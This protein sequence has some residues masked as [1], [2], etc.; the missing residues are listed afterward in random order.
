MIMKYKLYNIYSNVIYK[1]RIYDYIYIPIII[2]GIYIYLL[3]FKKI[4]L[5]N[6]Q[7]TN[8]IVSVCSV[9]AGFLFTA[10]TIIMGF[11]EEKPFIKLLKK[12][13]YYKK[14]FIEIILSEIFFILC[15]IFS[16]F[17]I[18]NNIASVLFVLGCC[19]TI[20]MLKLFATISFYVSQ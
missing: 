19:Y 17:S 11:P 15:I 7:F 9:F 3:Y 18:N 1:A 12:F 4:I 20:L 6:S 16:L 10:N 8:N 14:L 2:V 5:I 13:G